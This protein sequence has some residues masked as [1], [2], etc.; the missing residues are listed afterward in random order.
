MRKYYN[1]HTIWVTMMLLTLFTYSMGKFGFSGI[2]AVLFLLLAAIIKSTLIIREY[3]GLRGVSLL[4]R[5]I[6][7]GWL[8]IITI[9]IATTYLISSRP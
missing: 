9:A 3:M 1:A 6:M 8:S 2:Y 7:Y 4:W 5:S